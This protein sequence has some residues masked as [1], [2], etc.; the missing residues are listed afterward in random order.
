M[1]EKEVMHTVNISRESR[2]LKTKK[3]IKV[4]MNTL[5]TFYPFSALS[6]II[7]ILV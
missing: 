2:F 3:E 7:A 4:V 1:T 5:K 6:L